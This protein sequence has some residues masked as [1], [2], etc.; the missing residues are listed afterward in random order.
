M[1]APSSPHT[2][3]TQACAPALC[4][5]WPRPA[6]PS[7]ALTLTARLYSVCCCREHTHLPPT[8]A[9]RASEV[10][11]GSVLLLLVFRSGSPCLPQALQFP[12]QSLHMGISS[13]HWGCPWNPAL[14]SPGSGEATAAL[15]R[16]EGL[17]PVTRAQ[18]FPPQQLLPP[19]GV[20][21]SRSCWALAPG[22][23]VWR[24]QGHSRQISA[25]LC[26]N[27]QPRPAARPRRLFSFA[28]EL[29]P[30]QRVEVR[31]AASASSLPSR[32]AW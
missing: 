30:G 6:P 8:S 11:K 23:M 24:H 29:P 14:H 7:L 21:R 25:L 32:A 31:P 2:L 13:P 1:S 18:F 15:P 19:R 22:H 26:R 16:G 9:P 17:L 10:P 5:L 3:H 12:E 27:L 4:P 28:R 20:S